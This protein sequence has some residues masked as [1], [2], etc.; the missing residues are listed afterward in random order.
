MFKKMWVRLFLKIAAIFTAF[1]VILAV[2]NSTMLYNYYVHKEK[3][4][5]N[6]T[7]EKIDE[8]NLYGGDSAEEISKVIKDRDYALTITD[9]FG[10]VLFYSFNPSVADH[11]GVLDKGKFR[12]YAENPFK[13]EGF[14]KES[15]TGGEKLLTLKYTS[16]PDT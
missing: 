5:M 14:F 12:K 6:L 4:R 11:K 1:V 8:V 7:A 15:G 3:K 13:S 9:S 10:N 16:S 2:A